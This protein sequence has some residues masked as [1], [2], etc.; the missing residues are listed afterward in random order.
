MTHREAIKNLM[1][2]QIRLINDNSEEATEYNKKIYDTLAYFITQTIPLSVIEYITAEIEVL[3][4]DEEISVYA[5]S[6]LEGLI[7]RK[8]KEI[9]DERS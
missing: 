7:D 6:R 8:I 3:F 1:E 2:L 9:K 5:K 4:T